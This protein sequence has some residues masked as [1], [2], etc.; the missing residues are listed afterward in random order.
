MRRR[1]FARRLAASGITMMMAG[2]GEAASASD[3]PLPSKPRPG[4]DWMERAELMRHHLVHGVD[5][6]GVPYFDVLFRRP[7]AEVS[8]SFPDLVDLTGRYWEG[9]MLVRE[10]TGR[11]VETGPILLARGERNDLW[12]LVER[13]TRNH[14]VE[15]QIV[16]PS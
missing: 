12:D 5:K 16:D 1:E 15:S 4:F 7:Y 3:I 13:V 11:A 2:R 8:H 10:M 9:A 6:T 14:L